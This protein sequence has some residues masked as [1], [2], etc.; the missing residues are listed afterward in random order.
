MQVKKTNKR[1]I[2][3]DKYGKFEIY[4]Y[5][6]WHLIVVHD[7]R[8]NGSGWLIT[9]APIHQAELRPHMYNCLVKIMPNGAKVPVVFSGDKGYEIGSEIVFILN[10][11]L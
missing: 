3:I 6:P 8:V 2:E 11:K 4:G 10:S 1:K 5:S 9:D 7:D